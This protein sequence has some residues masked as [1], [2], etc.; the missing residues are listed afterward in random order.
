MIYNL[1][2][3]HTIIPVIFELLLFVQVVTVCAIS[4]QVCS[5]LESLEREYCR[6]EDWCKSDKANKG[7]KSLFITERCS[8]HHDQKESF[9]KVQ[10][11]QTL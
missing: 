8:K 2:F 1:S 10:T 9:L 7:D 6:A 4:S 5:V 11:W 3:S